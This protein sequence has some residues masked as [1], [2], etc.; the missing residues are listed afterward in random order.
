M[1]DEIVRGIGKY[2]EGTVSQLNQRRKSTIKWIK[3]YLGREGE[4]AEKW[5]SG[6]SRF[7]SQFLEH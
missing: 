2:S 1:G 5:G 4:M 7:P 3:K 6:E